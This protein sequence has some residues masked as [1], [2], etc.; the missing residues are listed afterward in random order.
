MRNSCQWLQIDT[1]FLLFSLVQKISTY[2]LHKLSLLTGASTRITLLNR[3]I[4][5]REETQAS[6]LSW[7][8]T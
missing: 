8:L 6:D 1:V 3:E 7:E 2:L 4:N 5:L